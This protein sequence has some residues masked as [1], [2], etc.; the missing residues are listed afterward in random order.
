MIVTF[1]HVLKADYTLEFAALNMIEHT[2]YYS[3]SQCAAFVIWSSAEQDIAVQE[4]PIEAIVVL[5]PLVLNIRY[6]NILLQMVLDMDLS[7][8][9]C[10]GSPRYIIIVIVS[11]GC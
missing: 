9:H 7:L 11:E 2:V 6:D 4:V 3:S 10:S 5:N 1:I 8:S